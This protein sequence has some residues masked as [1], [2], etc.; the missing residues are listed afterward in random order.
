MI[1][2]EWR[3]SL[4]HSILHQPSWNSMVIKVHARKGGIFDSDDLLKTNEEY[5][6][7]HSSLSLEW[8]LLFKEKC[9]LHGACNGSIWMEI[10]MQLYENSSNPV[11]TTIAS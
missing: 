2:I 1:N 11:T 5:G 9:H 7:L 8:E 6:R 10:V 4:V 3:H